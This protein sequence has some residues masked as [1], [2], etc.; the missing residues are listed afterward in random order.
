MRNFAPN[1]W[2]TSR[3][4]WYYRVL[5]DGQ[6][7]AGDQ[8]RLLRRPH[9]EWTIE[10]IQEYLHRTPDDMARVRELA[11]IDEFGAECRNAFRG[12]IAKAKARELRAALEAEDKGQWRE[13]R[14]ASKTQQTPRIAAFVFEAVTPLADLEDLN[15][16][17][18]VKLRLGNGLVRAYSVVG[19]DRNRFE[20]GV[21]LAEASR[22]ASHFLHNELRPGGTLHV[23]RFTSAV[24]MAASASHHE[25]VAGG[26]GLTAFLSLVEGLAAIHYSVVLHYAVRSAADVPFRD[27]VDRL[28]AAGVVRLYDKAQGQRLD[29]GRVVRGL[30]WNGRIGFCG[31]RR[32]MDEAARETA[33][34]GL[35]GDDVHFEAFE[36][37]ASGDPFDVVVANRGGRRLAVGGEETLLEV[38]RR[39][40][41]DD[42][43]PSSCEVGN[44]GTC[45]IAVKDGRIEHRGTALTDEEKARSMLSCVS[46]GVGSITVEL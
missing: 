46:R 16:G 11:A 17:A 10:R 23:G 3:T 21:A 29:V 27:R 32:M 40:F 30:P 35:G 26:V 4:G 38:L 33:A 7:R 6:V 24:P 28:R 19:G 37:D 22:G 18:H 31:P 42:D 1:T 8:L 15:P 39:Q 14:L 9:P 13:F 5:R 12:R 41:G 25:F 20:L 34:A 36:A 44:C 43:V 2:R 45:K